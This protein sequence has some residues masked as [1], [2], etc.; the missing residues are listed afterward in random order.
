MTAQAVRRPWAALSALCIGA[1]M[2]MLDATVVTVAMPTMIADLHASL[3]QAI[4]VIGGYTLT[5][6]VPLLLTSRLGDRLGRRAMFAAGLIVFTAASL[7]CAAAETVEVLIAARVVQGL[8]AAMMTPQQMALIADLFPSQRR[9]IAFGVWGAVVGC[10]TVTGPIFGGLMVLWAGWRSI[11]LVNVP[12]GIMALVL[13]GVFVPGGRSRAEQRFNLSGAML[14]GLGL[15]LIVFGVQN[16][17]QYEWGAVAGPITIQGL[18]GSGSVLLVVF[19]YTQ[20]LNREPLLDLSLFRYRTFSA[21]STANV[22]LGFTL[23][24]VFVP[25]IIYLQTVRGLSPS[26]SGLATMPM[27]VTSVLLGPLAGRLSDRFGGK[28]VAV[29]GFV[30]SACGLAVVTAQMRSDTDPWIFAPGLVAMGA[31]VA[32]LFASLASEAT[33]VVPTSLVGAA[34]GVFNTAR[35]VGAVL[36]TAGM[37]ALLQARVATATWPDLEHGLTKAVRE[38]LMLPI[39]VL[40]AGALVCAFMENSVRL[41]RHDTRQSVES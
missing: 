26:D 2:T 25:L 16:G 13:T 14:C 5:F 37:G 18:I 38:T 1:F 7:V 8:G 24:A 36:G 34:S 30:M 11:F 21:A 39:G 6:A 12:V 35:Q 4:W 23:A 31:G 15:F 22:A 40:A 27:A 28:L 3:N 10:A 20:R 32:C 9:G 33:R 29:T 41:K 19:L 17:Q